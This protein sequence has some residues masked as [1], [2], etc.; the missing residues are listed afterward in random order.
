LKWLRLSAGWQAI[1]GGFFAPGCVMVKGII[2]GKKKKIKKLDT[3]EKY[4]P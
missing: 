2:Y 1:F 4:M 3:I